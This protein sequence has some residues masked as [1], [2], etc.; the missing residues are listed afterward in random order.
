MVAFLVGLSVFGGGVF[1]SGGDEVHDGGVGE[2]GDVADLAVFGDVAKEAAHD[3]AGAGF[4]EFGH[5]HDLA[6]FGDGPDFL[7][8]VVA[9][10]LHGLFTAV[11]CGAAEDDERDDAL[12]GGGVGGADDGGFGHGGVGHQGGL[13]LGGGDAVAGHVHHV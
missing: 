9:Q 12:A 11:G 8:D 2:G 10:F 3:F 13:A 7:G 4:G 1:E 6:W 5:D